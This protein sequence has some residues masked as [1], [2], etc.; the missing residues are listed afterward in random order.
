[1]TEQE[2]IADLISRYPEDKNRALGVLDFVYR[3]GS[4]L[5]ALLYSSLFWPRFIEIQDMIFVTGRLKGRNLPEAKRLNDAVVT[6]GDNWRVEESF[7]IFELPSDLF[8]R[9]Q[10]TTDEQVSFLAEQL[11]QM[12]RAKLTFDFPDRRFAVRVLSPEETGGEVGITFYQ[13]PS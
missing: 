13:L 7:N 3:H 9:V 5:D 8:E 4:A 1:M 6:L 11:A 2:L 12:W 10:D